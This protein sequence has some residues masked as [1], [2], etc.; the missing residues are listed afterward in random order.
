MS[1]IYL[2]VPHHFCATY[3][4]PVSFSAKFSNYNLDHDAPWTLSYAHQVWRSGRVLKI[5]LFLVQLIVKKFN[6]K[7]RQNLQFNRSHVILHSTFN[8]N[9]DNK[10]F[11]RENAAP[12]S[13]SHMERLVIYCDVKFY[14][15]KILQH[16]TRE[17]KTA[18]V[19]IFFFPHVKKSHDVLD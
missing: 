14:S 2:L 9:L 19:T 16:F 8:H 4:E 17:L 13:R 12:H 3:S 15:K 5:Q 7:W 18:G 6:E 11:N 10:K 1:S